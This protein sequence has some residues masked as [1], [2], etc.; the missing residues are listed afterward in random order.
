MNI[1]LNKFIGGALAVGALASMASLASAQGRSDRIPTFNT[2]ID[3]RG[4]A[5]L[6]GKDYRFGRLQVTVQDNKRVTIHAYIGPLNDLVFTCRADRFDGRGN[7]IMAKVDS[8]AQ[9]RDAGPG[10]GDAKIFM[11]GRDRF[12]SVTVDGRDTDDHLGFSLRFAGSS[13]VRAYDPRDNPDS[14]D[15]DRNHGGSG[16]GGNHGNGGNRGNDGNSR[17]AMRFTDEETW[18]NNRQEFVMRYSLTLESDTDAKLVIESVQDRNMP[19]DKDDRHT[20]GDI[21]RYMVDGHNVNQSGHWSQHGDTVTITFD[22]IQTGG[23]PRSRTEKFTGH[24]R[25]GTLVMSDWDRTFYGHDPR[26]AFVSR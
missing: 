15:Y 17:R 4:T 22:T 13:Q 19:N 9:G 23:A 12:S 25:N 26:F 10:D 3:G 6:R 20:H 7:R 21:L 16:N 8:A 2:T 1:Q 18:R 5:H 11:S 24:L 14:Q